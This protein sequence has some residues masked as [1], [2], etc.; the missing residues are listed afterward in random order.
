[1]NDIE[2]AADDWRKAEKEAQDAIDYLLTHTAP[3]PGA[4]SALCQK[5]EEARAAFFKLQN[6]S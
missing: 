2:Q 6:W 4:V 3:D 1:V 5:R